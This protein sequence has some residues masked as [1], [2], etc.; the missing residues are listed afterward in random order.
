VVFVL[1]F[2]W[3][4][5]FIQFF[6]RIDEVQLKDIKSL[7]D[8]RKHFRYHFKAQDPEFGTVKEEVGCFFVMLVNN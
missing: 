6:Y 3:T 7:F 8:K 1:N 4:V 2:W 5:I